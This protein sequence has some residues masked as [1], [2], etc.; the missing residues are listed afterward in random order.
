VGGR[1]ETLLLGPCARGDTDVARVHVAFSFGEPTSL[2]IHEHDH[3]Y[4]LSC[5]LKLVPQRI[6]KFLP[7]MLGYFSLSVPAGLGA[8][9]LEA[10]LHFLLKCT[11]QRPPHRIGVVVQSGES[12]VGCLSH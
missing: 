7:L 3:S 10:E 5:D 6:L 11:T 4:I 8:V 12:I 1:G 9:P 2:F